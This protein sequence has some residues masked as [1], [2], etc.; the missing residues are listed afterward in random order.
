MGSQTRMEP[1][2]VALAN[3]ALVGYSFL[4]LGI[5]LYLRPTRAQATHDHKAIRRS[6]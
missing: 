6:E 2:R 4:S 1:L 5:A 3:N